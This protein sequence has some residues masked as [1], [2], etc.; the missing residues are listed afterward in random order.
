MNATEHNPLVETP[1]L[2]VTQ[3]QTPT[4]A[5][6]STGAQ[7]GRPGVCTASLARIPDGSGTAR[8]LHG[9][10]LRLWSAV[11]VSAVARPSGDHVAYAAAL[12]D[13]NV[14]GAHCHRDHLFALGKTVGCAHQPIGDVHFFSTG[15][16][17]GL[18]CA[19]LYNRAV[20]GSGPGCAPGRALSGQ[21]IVGSG[22]ALRRYPARAG[23]AVG[24]PLRGVHHR[25]HSDVR[26]PLFFQSSPPEH[27][28]P[29]SLP[30]CWS[31]PTSPWKRRS[32]G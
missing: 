31:Q 15:Q 21:A 4:Q 22:G 25:I 20:P 26:R 8:C 18:G 24:G 11:R 7:T 17:Q 10:G 27:A 5:A 1:N 13:G 3:L 29:D 9:V 12:A 14:D 16:N 2:A 30:A 28:T 32:P 19:L 6:M 23:W